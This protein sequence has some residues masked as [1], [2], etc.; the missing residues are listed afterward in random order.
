[1]E[2]DP[3]LKPILKYWNQSSIVPHFCF[4]EQTMKSIEGNPKFENI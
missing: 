3:I 4:L 1:M 2:A